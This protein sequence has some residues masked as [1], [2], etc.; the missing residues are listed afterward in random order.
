M[1]VAQRTKAAESFGASHTFVSAGKKLLDTR[2]PTFRAVT[3]VRNT[4]VRFLKHASLPFPESGIRLIR[5]PDLQRITE[6]L[7][8]FQLELNSAVSELDAEFD[9]MK[10]A[11]RDRFGDLY[12]PSDYPA[13]LSPQFTMAWDFPSVEPPSYLRQL[14]PELYQQETARVRARFDEAVRLAEAAFTE[15]LASM[16][17]HLADRL[18]GTDDGRPKTFRDSAVEN[19]QEFFQRFQS[20]NIGS[21]E[22]LD[23]LVQQS[24]AILNGVGPQELRGSAGLRQQITT[25]LSAV[26]N[27]LDG[28][29]VDRPRRNIQRRPR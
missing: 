20:L 13:S 1:S 9:A 6:S 12:S 2:E 22:Q 3:T 7:E 28:L 11:A 4:A 19:L 29:M 24:Q 5:R 18:S 10:A 27:S 14:S 25:Q 8:G 23:E 26:Q 21:N 16:V 15:E 17:D